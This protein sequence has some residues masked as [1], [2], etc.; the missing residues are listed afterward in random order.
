M[1]MHQ[2]TLPGAFAGDNYDRGGIQK[3]NEYF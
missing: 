2:K 1:E 3:G